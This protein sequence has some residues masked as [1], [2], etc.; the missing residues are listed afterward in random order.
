MPV[1]PLA[2]ALRTLGSGRSLSGWDFVRTLPAA[3]L[4]DDGGAL[5]VCNDFMKYCRP[6]AQSPYGRLTGK[7]LSLHSR[8]AHEM[9]LK[10]AHGSLSPW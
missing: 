7:D 1:T 2:R 8:V 4:I 6:T 5:N 3:H 9:H 10:E